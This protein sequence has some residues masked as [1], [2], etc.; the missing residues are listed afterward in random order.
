MTLAERQ[1]TQAREQYHQ[2]DFKLSWKLL[3]QADD[4]MRRAARLLADGTT[5]ERLEMEMERT[6]ALMEQ[7]RNRLG[8]DPAPQALRLLADPAMGG[9]WPPSEASVPRFV[10]GRVRFE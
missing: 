4:L 2:G 8:T 5:P 7:I 9:D 1:A 6:R 3:E 10:A